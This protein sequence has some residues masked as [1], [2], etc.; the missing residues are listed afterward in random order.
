LAAE[1]ITK[2]P[3]DPFYSKKLERAADVDHEVA[4]AVDAAYLKFDEE[5][6]IAKAKTAED[7]KLEDPF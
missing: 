4:D 3:E 5:Y 6:A 7:L 2:Y 1:D